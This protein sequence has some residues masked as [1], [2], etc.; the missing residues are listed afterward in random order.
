MVE[1]ILTVRFYSRVRRN[2]I[3][4]SLFR[5]YTLIRE[6]FESESNAALGQKMTV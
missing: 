3:Q 5:A 4:K 2:S 6:H 1:L